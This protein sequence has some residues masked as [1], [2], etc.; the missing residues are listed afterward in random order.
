MRGIIAFV[1]S[2]CIILGFLAIKDRLHLMQQSTL[3]KT[4]THHRK[5]NIKP[6]VINTW[7]F[8]E[9]TQIAWSI[10][11]KHKSALDGIE[12]GCTRC[13]ELQCDRTVG[14]G[15]S[16]DENG[17]TTLDAMIMDG[18]TLRVGAVGS[19]RHIK[20]AIKAARLV[21]ETTSHSLLVGLQASQFANE[22]G[23]DIANLTTDESAAMHIHWKH[24]RCQPNFRMRGNI[25]PDPTKHCGPYTYD[26]HSDIIAN[27]HGMLRDMHHTRAALAVNADDHAL[28]S[29]DTIAMI[30]MD[31]YG[32][33]ASGCST[34]GAIHKVPGRVGDS[35][36]AGAGSY[37]DSDVGGCGATGDGDVHLRFL[38]CMVVMESM[39]NG[40]SPKDAAERAVRRIAEREPERYVGAVIALDKNGRHGGAMY[41]FREFSYA[42]RSEDSGGVKVVDVAP[43]VL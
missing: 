18:D 40:M 20:T 7:P 19:L 41:G 36:I 35:A 22:M 6:I 15:G 5:S 37:A 33:I 2:L 27:D 12:A 34:N 3:E 23:L 25:I 9:A 21:M 14:Y 17:E 11:E 38:P 8:T 39:R 29:H 13:E 26:R 30:A 10:L 32:K 42:W 1:V 24:H 31:E 43:L 28:P 16:P 4:K